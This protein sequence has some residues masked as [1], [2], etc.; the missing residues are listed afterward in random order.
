MAEEIVFLDAREAREQ[1][2]KLR[3]KKPDYVII[4]NT[5]W[6]T[7]VVLRDAKMLGLDAKFIGLIWSSDEKIIT[8][9]GRDAEGFIGTT[10]FVAMDPRLPGV[11]E[12]I[13]FNRRRNGRSDSVMFLYANGWTTAKV[14][15][16]GARRAGDDLSGER[17]RKELEGLSSFSTGGITD[18]Y[19][20][21]E[22]NHVGLRR[23]RLCQVTAGKWRPITDF[24]GA[25]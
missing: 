3:E 19:S 13:D 21:S 20:F 8:L 18:V 23:L 24:V 7:Y 14:M 9:A 25:E 1:I 6:P 22:N 12:I 2:L 16:E 11:R 5:A 17:I 15:L 10:P 4:N